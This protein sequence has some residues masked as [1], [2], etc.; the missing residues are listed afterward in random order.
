MYM[1]TALPLEAVRPT[2]RIQLYPRRLR[3]PM[4]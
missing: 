2:C 3:G 1:Y 4:Q